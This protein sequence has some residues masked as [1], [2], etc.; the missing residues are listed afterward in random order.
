M[1]AARLS[2]TPWLHSYSERL[3]HDLRGQKLWI[4]IVD[5]NAM[6]PHFALGALQD[7]RIVVILIDA[8]V[9]IAHLRVAVYASPL[10]TAQKV[11]KREGCE[12]L[13]CPRLLA[14]EA[15]A[16]SML[17]VAAAHAQWRPV[18]V[19]HHKWL[20]NPRASR[21][22][23]VIPRKEHRR[24]DGRAGSFRAISELIPVTLR[25]LTLELLVGAVAAL[26]ELGAVADVAA[27]TDA[28][29]PFIWRLLVAFHLARVAHHLPFVLELT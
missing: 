18:G 4:V 21:R 20:S 27:R 7:A 15:R 24:A 6:R 25:P 28:C 5:G 11:G 3:G 22:P 1:A 26:I 17:G 12:R 10:Q 2:A 9:I 8:H 19:A 23:R 16:Q 13:A 29:E 14:V